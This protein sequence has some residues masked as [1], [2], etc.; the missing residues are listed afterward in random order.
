M[1]VSH[2]WVSF[3]YTDM[4]LNYVSPS[5]IKI[6]SPVWI[7]IACIHNSCITNDF[8]SCLNPSK[9]FCNVEKRLMPITRQ[10]SDC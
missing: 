2:P 9:Y 10:R 1:Q 3:N 4:R 5:K 7:Q 6:E 8:L